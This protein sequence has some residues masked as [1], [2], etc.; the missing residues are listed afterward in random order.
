MG[1]PLQPTDQHKPPEIGSTSAMGYSSSLIGNTSKR[2]GCPPETSVPGTEL[3]RR[4]VQVT[5]NEANAVLEA[6]KEIEERKSQQTSGKLA[7]F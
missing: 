1:F 6:P 4:S 5:K 3:N 2:L 7:R